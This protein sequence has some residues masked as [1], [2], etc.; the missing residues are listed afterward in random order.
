MAN[1]TLSGAVVPLLKA[2]GFRVVSLI[3]ELPRS[4]AS[5]KL[6]ESLAALLEESDT[7]VVPA[8]K[9]ADAIGSNASPAVR[10]R[11]VVRPQGLYQQL[12]R[13]PDARSLCRRRLG[14][15]DDARIV[16]NVGF[17]DLRKGIDTFV[18]VAS[19]RRAEPTTCTSSGSGTSM[20][21]SSAG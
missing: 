17:G 8:E 11:I 19:S 2:E 7:I 18:H 3:H 6:E 15:G 9:V 4:S 1:T 12:T 10:E 16:L 20:P 21:T 5:S 13:P 14:I